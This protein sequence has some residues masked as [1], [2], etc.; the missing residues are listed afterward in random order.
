MLPWHGLQ[1]P[2]AMS[3][4]SQARKEA[5]AVCMLHCETGEKADLPEYKNTSARASDLELLQVFVVWIA[6]AGHVLKAPQVVGTVG[7]KR[8][9]LDISEIKGAAPC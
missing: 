5:L 3:C 4:P 6:K 9:I 2:P 1:V 8:A 7:T